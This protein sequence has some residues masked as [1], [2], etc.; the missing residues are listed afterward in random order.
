MENSL[1]PKVSII[2]TFYNSVVLGN[3]VKKTMEC[4]LNQTYKNLEIICV[5]DGSVDG[6][7]QELQHYAEADSRVT[8]IDKE[9]E[10]TAQYAKAAG[11]DVAT[12]EWVMLFD[13]DD[14][15]DNNAIEKAIKKTQADNALDMVS[16]IVIT[17]FADGRIEHIYNLDHFITNLEEYHDIKISG[18]NAFKKTVG[19]YDVHFRGI[20]RRDLFKSESFR[21]KKKLLN[22]DEIVERKILKKARYVG[23]CNAV[24]RHR[25]FYNSS[26][27]AVSPKR[28]D[29]VETDL[30][31]REYFKKEN[32]YNERKDIFELTAYKNFVNSVKLF[33]KLKKQMDEQKKIRYYS[34]IKEAYKKLDKK[35][36]ISQFNGISKIYNFLLLNN[37]SI[38]ILFYRFKK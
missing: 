33:N 3:F 35:N 21:F 30:Y 13:H 20:V 32:V 38:L 18:E 27:K 17:E 25:I 31:L 4:L 36:I 7:L 16:F 11:Q 2:A 9:N 14:I 28:I 22:A 19:R 1:T 6:T 8:L 37:F 5:N 34:A 23:V 15:M 24:Y 12:G 29:L 26:A 10:G